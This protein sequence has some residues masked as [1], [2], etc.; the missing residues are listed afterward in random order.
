MKIFWVLL[1]LVSFSAYPLTQ[2]QNKTIGRVSQVYGERAG[3]RINTWYNLIQQLRFKSK[4]QQLNDV[5]VFFNRLFYI[6]DRKMWGVND[7]WTTPF[8]FLGA[9]GG[10]CEDYAIA[11][12]Y[13]LKQ[14][15]FDDNTLRLIY[16]KALQLNEFHMVLAYYPTPSSTPL[17]LDNIDGEIKKANK[18]KD[19]YPIYSFNASKLW[20]MKKNGKTGA[21]KGSSSRI[22]LWKKVQDR[23]RSLK[24]KKPIINF[25]E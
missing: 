3:L 23:E 21:V 8:E 15:G 20:L 2:S 11:K 5:N 22:S 18:R 12:Y 9:R 14:L 7:F 25:D 17:I 6:S 10:D 24:L 16:V 13:T 19:L 1:L 4:Q